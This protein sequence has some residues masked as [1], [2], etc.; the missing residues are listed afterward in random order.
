MQHY[1]CMFK[2][3]VMMDEKVCEKIIDEYVRAV[4]AERK[5][6]IADISLMDVLKDDEFDEQDFQDIWKLSE[7]IELDED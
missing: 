6:D 7:E 3:V 1:I 2:G 4:V 5:D